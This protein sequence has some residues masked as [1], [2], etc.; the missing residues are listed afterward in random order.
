MINIQST[1]SSSRKLSGDNSEIVLDIRG[2][3]AADFVPYLGSN[4]Q[5]NCLNLITP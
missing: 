3:R 1:L 5:Y 2:A 4:S